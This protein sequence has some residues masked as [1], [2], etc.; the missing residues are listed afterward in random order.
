MTGNSKKHFFPFWRLIFYYFLYGPQVTKYWREYLFVKGKAS[1]YCCFKTRVSSERIQKDIVTRRNWEQDPILHYEM[2]VRQVI[3]RG[4]IHPRKKKSDE[5]E[6]LN[7]NNELEVDMVFGNE[8][9]RMAMMAEI[10]EDWEDEDEMFLV[11]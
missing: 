5:D 8:E 7:G 3:R 6:E 11:E 1:L 9:E 2:T 10:E 4:N